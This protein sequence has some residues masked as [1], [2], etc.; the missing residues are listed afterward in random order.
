PASSTTMKR[1]NAQ[2]AAAPPRPARNGTAEGAFDATAPSAAAAAAK[3]NAELGRRATPISS[4][5]MS[6]RLLQHVVFVRNLLRVE[7]L[8][9]EALGLDHALA[10][11]RRPAVVRRR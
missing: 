2:P 9:P 1:R 7:L 3:A 4:R 8:L 11:H 5:T 6:S 10:R